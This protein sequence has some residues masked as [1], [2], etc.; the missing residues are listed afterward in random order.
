MRSMG[1]DTEAE[2]RT[3][4]A[5]SGA[6]ITVRPKAGGGCY[7]GSYATAASDQRIR[8]SAGACLV[9]SA[10]PAT[11]Y[12]QASALTVSGSRI[13]M[14]GPGGITGG[15]FYLN[16]RAQDIRMDGRL[17]ISTK[18]DS[19]NPDMD[20]IHIYGTRILME[21]VSITSRTY[22]SY[23]NSATDLV[24]ANSSL[25]SHG[26][27]ESCLRI[28]GGLRVVVM[29][30]RLVNPTHHTFRVHSASTTLP[31]DLVYFGRNQLEVGGVM[32]NNSAGNPDPQ[33]LRTWYQD[34]RFYGGTL[35][36]GASPQNIEPV[37]SGN[38]L[39]SGTPPLWQ[40]Q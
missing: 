3:A 21:G 12:A 19:T 6:D 1:V 24:I 32:S 20:Q 4:L 29:D 23:S 40:M 26:G 7:L 18:R 5:T 34:N 33:A 28:V 11:S 17:V 25:V 31:S 37:V 30:N 35:Q 13:H 27:E 36:I 10:S 15:S 9:A 14:S 22:C 8:I 2:L 38:S 39:L 16:A